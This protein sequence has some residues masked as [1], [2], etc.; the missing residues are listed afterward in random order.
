M[1]IID[2]LKGERF[3]LISPLPP[4]KVAAQLDAGLESMWTPFATGVIGWVA[5]PWFALRYQR[6]A[7]FRRAPRLVLSGRIRPH[8]TGSRITAAYRAPRP[9]LLFLAIW[10]GLFGFFILRNPAFVGLLLGIAGAQLAVLFMLMHKICEEADADL[11]RL[12][13][14]VEGAAGLGD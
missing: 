9:L 14:A 5:A 4:E 2:S 3:T 6:S 7:W 10:F 13:A 12:L 11:P 1:R 8:G